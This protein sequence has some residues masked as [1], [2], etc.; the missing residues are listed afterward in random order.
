MTGVKVIECCQ[1]S[2]GEEHVQQQKTNTDS[3][4]NLKIEFSTRHTYV[5]HRLFVFGRRKLCGHFTVDRATAEACLWYSLG[6]LA[7]WGEFPLFNYK[8]DI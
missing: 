2:K 7:I 4:A 3:H 6:G 1:T 5:N 8:L